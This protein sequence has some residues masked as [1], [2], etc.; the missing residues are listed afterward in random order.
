MIYSAIKERMNK[1]VKEIKKIYQATID[2]GEPEIFHKKCDNVPN[3]LILYKTAGNRR[4]GAFASECWDNSNRTK[5]DK[6]C[7][8]FSLDKNKIYP[9]KNNKYYKIECYSC[10]G[11]SFVNGSYYCIKIDQNSAIKNKSLNTYENEHPNSKELFD[12][13]LN[14]LSEDVEFKGIY[15]EEY[16]VFQI[17]F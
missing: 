11:P 17:L 7:F 12:G 9:S 15:A 3:T 13:E 2:G 8:L 1:E 14:A 5:I 16:E 10:E 6:N 4:F